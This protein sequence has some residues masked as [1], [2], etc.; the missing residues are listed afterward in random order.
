M[1]DGCPFGQPSIVFKSAFFILDFYYNDKC[2][3]KKQNHFK[4]T[5][6]QFGMLYEK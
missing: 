5:F 2:D 6:F 1:I 4:E 3:C